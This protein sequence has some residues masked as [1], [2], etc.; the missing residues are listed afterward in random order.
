MFAN[1]RTED[2]D[3]EFFAFVTD[4]STNI[5]ARL[6]VSHHFLH[7][8]SSSLLKFEVEDYGFLSNRSGDQYQ[9]CTS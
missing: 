4:V 6:L 9:V 3:G 2:V 1:F 5:T 7:V 8:F